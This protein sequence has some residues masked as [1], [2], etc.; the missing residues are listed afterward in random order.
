MLILSIIIILNSYV[1]DFLVFFLF[2]WSSL[3][4]NVWKKKSGYEIREYPS[5]IV[6]QTTVEGHMERL[7]AL[8]LGF[9]W[10][11]FWR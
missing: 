2:E 1:V 10:L 5:R 6:A 7:L 9:S 4:I 11:H 8:V 3:L